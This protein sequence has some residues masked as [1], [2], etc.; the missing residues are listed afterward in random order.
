LKPV[1]NH[2]AKIDS[3][4]V[5]IVQG[6]YPTTPHRIIFKLKYLEEE[7]EWKLVGVDVNLKE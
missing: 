3:D 6:Y 7:S 5:L 1:F 4:G 2:P